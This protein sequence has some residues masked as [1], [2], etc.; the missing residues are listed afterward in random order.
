M[1]QGQNH[2]KILISSEAISV[3]E[4]ESRKAT[5]ETGGVLFGVTS[6]EGTIVVTHAT[7]PGPNA[8]HDP[9]VFENDLQY[10]QILLNKMNAKFNVDY[11]G[12]WHKHLGQMTCPSQGD[13]NTARSILKD[14]EWNKEKLVVVIATTVKNQAL[15]SSFFISKDNFSFCP[16][17]LE[18]IQLKGIHPEGELPRRAEEIPRNGEKKERKKKEGEFEGAEQ[19]FE[20]KEGR[21]RLVVEKES[22]ENIGLSCKT[23]LRR[24][25]RLCFIIMAKN[26][27]QFDKIIMTLPQDYPG[28]A[29]DVIIQ[30]GEKLIRFRASKQISWIP[31]FK[32]SD[33]VS[34]LVNGD[35]PDYQELVNKLTDEEKERREYTLIE[36]ADHIIN[37]IMH[38]FLK[39]GSKWQM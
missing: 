27:V 15:I 7:K 4:E 31:K 23:I 1:I 29:P 19:W 30:V 16:I 24:D 18:V 38:F 39:G 11:V 17:E 2:P 26:T 35:S 13:L 37:D 5:M 9:A 25:K 12:E 36:F 22:L 33:L 20:T 14:P 32:I 28:S 8:F 3:I 34:D 21:N 10:Q 6:Q